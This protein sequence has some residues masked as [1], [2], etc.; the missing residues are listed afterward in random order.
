MTAN[1]NRIYQ[2]FEKE[3]LENIGV[4]IYVKFIGLE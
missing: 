3:I 4:F 2:I 1:G